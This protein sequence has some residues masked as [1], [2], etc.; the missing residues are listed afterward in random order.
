MRMLLT[1]IVI[2]IVCVMLSLNA[3]GYSA[4]QL[5]NPDA[6]NLKKLSHE[7][8]KK[9]PAIPVLIEFYSDENKNLDKNKSKKIVITL[10]E[11]ALND[12]KFYYQN[13]TGSESDTLNNSIK[14]FQ[15]A[16]GGKPTGILNG[17]EFEM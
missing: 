14:N 16:I 2:I 15:I 5:N 8:L 7:T 6:K 11:M 12:L 9:M 4:D 3:Y 13:P 17:E 10:I 1:K